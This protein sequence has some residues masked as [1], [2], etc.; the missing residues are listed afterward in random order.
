MTLNELKFVTN[1]CLKNDWITWLY[2]LDN[3]IQN[4]M[5]CAPLRCQQDGEDDDKTMMNN[6]YSVTSNDRS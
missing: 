5:Y 3:E 2:W 4:A 6:V 1:C